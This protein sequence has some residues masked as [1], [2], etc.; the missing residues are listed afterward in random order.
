MW[1]II[2][3]TPAVRKESNLNRLTKSVCKCVGDHLEQHKVR[4]LTSGPAADAPALAAVLPDAE[5]PSTPR[6]LGA[7]GPWQSDG[8][9]AWE[10]L[11]SHEPERRG[12]QRFVRSDHH[13]SRLGWQWWP[14]R[15]LL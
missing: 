12:T 7:V 8:G 3:V 1:F 11:L 6:V 9:P 15:Q 14:F 10:T 2:A 4:S 13:I 5:P